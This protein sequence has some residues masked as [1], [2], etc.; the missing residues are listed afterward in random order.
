[1]ANVPFNP[2]I[3]LSPAEKCELITQSRCEVENTTIDLGSVPKTD[4]ITV[5]ILAVRDA[6]IELGRVISSGKNMSIPLVCSLMESVIQTGWGVTKSGSIPTSI[7]DRLTKAL[8][9]IDA[10]VLNKVWGEIVDYVTGRN[11]ADIDAL[12]ASRQFLQFLQSYTVSFGDGEALNQSRG[13]T[14]S[15]SIG[16]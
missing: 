11:S 3:P 9:S 16:I 14:F 6:C 10:G 8:S 15:Q 2:Q 7:K 12:M 5:R 4:D 13:T 1:M